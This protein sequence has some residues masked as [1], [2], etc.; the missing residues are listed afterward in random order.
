M[1]MRNLTEHIKIFYKSD[2]RL[3]R[4]KIKNQM[5]T[6]LN[7]IVN[8]DINKKKYYSLFNLG[9]KNEKRLIEKTN[10]IANMMGKQVSQNKEGK[11]NIFVTPNINKLSK[12]KKQIKEKLRYHQTNLGGSIHTDGPQINTP[13]RFLIMTCLQNSKSGGESII[14]NGEKI[15][16]HIKDQKKKYYNI[17][18]KKIYFERRGFTKNNSY[19]FKKPIFH[20][21][22]KKLQFFRYLKDYILSAYKLK[23][24]SLPE[25]LKAALIY[26]D[27]CLENKKF[28]K[29]YKMKIGDI[30]IIN[31]HKLAHGRSKFS[32]NKHNQRKILRVWVN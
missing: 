30:I 4:N 31:N 1:N 23:K 24:I 19:I 22:N 8:N 32:I 7:G 21:K 29:K 10:L 27:K 25:S 5:R 3:Q 11:K 16:N 17:L 26:F 2:N 9:E 15:F 28:Q 13:P 14:V 20:I 6:I 12:F 18:K